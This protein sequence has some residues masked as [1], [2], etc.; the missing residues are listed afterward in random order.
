[1]FLHEFSTVE[2][3]WNFPHIK[4]YHSGITLS[5]FTL[6]CWCCAWPFIIIPRRCPQ[7]SLHCII[8]IAATR[9]TAFLH[10]ISAAA[11]TH[12]LTLQCRQNRIPGCR[13]GKTRK[14]PKGNSDWQWGGCSDD[15]K[16]GEKETRRFIDKLEKGKDARTAF[17]L[18]NNQVGRKVRLVIYSLISVR[19]SLLV[20]VLLT[21][22]LTVGGILKQLQ[23]K[24]CQGH[25][26]EHNRLASRLASFDL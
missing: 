17:N 3:L 4:L 6:P 7:F 16:F 2:H 1:M 5:L 19:I 21:Q 13:C 12:E 15:I 11:I 9:E 23:K 26:N 14:Q 8:F 22:N 24:L 10:A 18:H 20:K 25:E